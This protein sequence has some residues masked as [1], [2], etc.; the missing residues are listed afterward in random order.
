MFKNYLKRIFDLIMKPEMKIL[1][2]QLA[3]FLILSIFPLLTLLGYIGSKISMLSG[4]FTSFIERFLPTSL[5]N[6]ILP[7]LLD[8]NISGN[9]TF[10]MLVGFILVSNGTHSLIITSDELYGIDYGDYLKRRVKAFFMIFI[11]LFLFS[12]VIIFLAYGN[13][14][15]NHIMNLDFLQNFRNQIYFVFMMIKWPISFILFFWIL[16]LL[17]TIAPDEEI[18]SKFMN[19][20]A[21]FTTVGWIV[22]TYV[23]S[24]YV[25]NFANYSLFY[26]SLSGIIVM[27]IWIYI[28]SFIFVMGIA[29]NAEEY[30]ASK[31]R[32]NKV[33][34][35]NNK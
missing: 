33:K 22:T 16:K 20:G 19:K 5:T 24:Y 3:Y 10:V 15:I 18:P 17:Y 31:S 11:L 1:P 29:I 28:I 9:V 32:I 23:Y 35:A 30:L 14:I 2:G 4:P 7:F 12:F 21:L 6:I 26:G 25:S 34:K 8:S 13:I 27:M